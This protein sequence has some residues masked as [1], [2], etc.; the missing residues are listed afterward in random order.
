MTIQKQPRASAD[1][2]SQPDCV[3]V[4]GPIIHFIP[5]FD[6]EDIM[7]GLYQT[8]TKTRHQHGGCRK[9]T[10]TFW[11]SMPLAQIS[12]LMFSLLLVYPSEYLTEPGSSQ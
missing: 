11:M 3:A 1:S 4:A 9:P 12:S 6:T 7:L 5:F 2:P 8:A 10:P